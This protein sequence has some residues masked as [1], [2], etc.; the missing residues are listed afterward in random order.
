MDGSVIHEHEIEPLPHVRRRAHLTTASHAQK[1]SQRLTMLKIMPDIMRCQF[2][3]SGGGGQGIGASNEKFKQVYAVESRQS[4]NTMDCSEYD[5]A[6]GNVGSDPA[7][8]SSPKIS[9]LVESEEVDIDMED[10]HHKPRIC[11]DQ[12]VIDMARTYGNA[13]IVGY[14]QTAQSPLESVGVMASV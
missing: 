8:S 1:P 6:A 13:V 2:M 4:P 14:H 11:Y 10:I 9:T 7:T 5:E 3:G 12:N